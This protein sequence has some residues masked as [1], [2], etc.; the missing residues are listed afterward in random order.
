VRHSAG[1]VEFFT[2]KRHRLIFLAM[3][4]GLLVGTSSPLAFWAVGGLET[5]LFTLLVTSGIHL[6]VLWLQGSLSDRAGAAKGLMLF[7]AV[8][9]RPDA[10]ISSSSTE[11]VSASGILVVQGMYHIKPYS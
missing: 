8:L 1:I 4:A 3:C 7:M 5:T 10:A 9:A 11:Q 6:E 2:W